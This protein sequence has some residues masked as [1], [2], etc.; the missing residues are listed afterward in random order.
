MLVEILSFQCSS[1]CSHLSLPERVVQEYFRSLGGKSHLKYAVN[2]LRYTP[3]EPP[4]NLLRLCVSKENRVWIKV[5]DQ[6]FNFFFL[7]SFYEDSLEGKLE[8]GENAWWGC[9]LSPEPGG[10]IPTCSWVTDV[11][12]S[13]WEEHR[14]PPGLAPLQKRWAVAAILPL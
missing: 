12:E 8:T 2:V 4:L 3:Q 11:R 14:C 13:W 7:V 5:A 9:G 10:D 6:N 1:E